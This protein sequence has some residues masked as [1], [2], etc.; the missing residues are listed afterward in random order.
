MAIP[1]T[2]SEKV[3][4][5]RVDGTLVSYDQE[6]F[7]DPSWVSM[8][9]GFNIIPDKPKLHFSN[10]DL[11][12]LRRMLEKMKSAIASGVEYAPHHHEFLKTMG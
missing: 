11:D 10:A 3:E 5:F 7:K 12:S 9:N 8:Y 2:L 1:D 6:T 4:R